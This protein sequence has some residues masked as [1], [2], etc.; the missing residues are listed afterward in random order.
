MQDKMTTSVIVSTTNYEMFKLVGTNRIIKQRNV[1]RLMKSFELTGGMSMSKPI[2]VDRNHNVID[3]QHRL[4][5]CKKMGIPVHY[6]VSDDKIENIPIYNTY[7]EKWG[8]EDYARYWAEQGNENY[9]RILAIRDRVSIALN[10]VLECLVVAG[11]YKNEV[12]KEGRFVFDGD[13]DKSV[14]Y[15]QKILQ[16]CYVV[17][18]KR[19]VSSKML[20]AI[21]FLS[22]IKSFD[23]DT[24]LEKIMRYQ[25]KL[26]TCA[27]SEEYIQMFTSLYNYKIRVNR[28][29]PEEL[30]AA[31]NI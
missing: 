3:G 26:Y 6:I 15:I 20:R 8:L 23:L 25:G 2:I 22:R 24:L 9:K 5:A 19:N 30:L 17:K 11:G 14:E 27:T 16:L 13:I 28:I 10:G 18:G 12:F 29:S 21:R 31:K 4:M 1:E 7:Q